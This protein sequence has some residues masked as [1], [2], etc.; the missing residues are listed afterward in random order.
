[1]NLPDINLYN[2]LFDN[3]EINYRNSI[4]LE[5]INAMYESI[6]IDNICKYHDIHSYNLSLPTNCPDYLNIFHVNTR[7]LNKNYDKLISLITSLP[8]IP[9]IL[10]LSETW[11]SPNTA[12]LH[13]INGFKSYHTFRP[14]GYG[15]VAI[16]VKDSISSSPQIDYCMCTDNIEL[17]TVKITVGNTSYVISSLYR[18]HSKHHQVKEFTDLMDELLSQNFFMNNKC[19]ITGDFNINLLEH[20]DHPPTNNFLSMM[21]SCNYI[22]H[23]SRPTRFPDDNSTATPSLLD[24]IW[25][26]FTAPSSPGILFSPLSDHLPI[27]LNLPIIEKLNETHKLS[28]RIKNIE[29]CAK[30]QAKLSEVNWYSLL[31]HHDTNINCNV[32]LDTI[33]SLYYSSFPKA[34]K[35]IS[36]KRLQNPWITQGIIKSIHHK[37]NLYK[38]YKLGIIDFDVYKQFR[39]YLTKLIQITKQNYYLQRF[40]DFRLSTKKIWLTINELSNSIKKPSSTTKSV[41]LNNQIFDTQLEVSEA[42]N[43]HFTNI[44]P[45]LANKLPPADTSPKSFLR[46]NYPHSMV[47]PL[48]TPDDTIQVINTLK[49]KKTY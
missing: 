40:S 29:N 5:I 11:F 48:A 41:F 18:P 38:S 30:F 3:E 26:N 31:T 44:A 7:S 12:P 33:Y 9:D 43:D 6:N 28:F 32:F 13:E 42:F 20:N 49:N 16:Y 36:T 14:V 19:I 10:C 23:I 25:T 22:P 8:K 17:C 46:R 21:Q 27:Y 35:Q 37:Y 2:T 45:K 4:D 1:M 47:M 24:H 34:T 39:N 15:G